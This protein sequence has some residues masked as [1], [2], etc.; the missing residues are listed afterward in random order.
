MAQD[1][2]VRPPC[3]TRTNIMMDRD[4]AGAQMGLA[5]GRQGPGN[6]SEV[7]PGCQPPT[8]VA[9]RSADCRGQAAGR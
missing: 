4:R 5:T 2:A 1:K 3:P 7:N 8:N 9:Q 6:L